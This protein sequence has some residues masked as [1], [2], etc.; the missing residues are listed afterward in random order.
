[1]GLIDKFIFEKRGA[2]GCSNSVY[3]FA[4]TTCCERVGVI[5]DGL[6]DFYW[7]AETP[8]RSI[9]LL[10]E[11]TCPFC[12]ASDWNLRHIDNIDHVPEHWRWACDNLPRPG[13]RR[14]LPL[15]EHIR[16][17][18]ALCRRVASPI[19]TWNATLLLNTADARVRY[20]RGWVVASDALVT[21]AEFTPHFEKLLLSGYSWINLSAYGIFRNDLIVGVESPCEALGVAAGLTS[22]NYSGPSFN[23]DGTPSWD[24]NLVIE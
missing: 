14:L 11:S 2:S 24:L 21:V 22:V 6:S 1:M 23:V 10:D 20:D 19:P 5:D 12:D 3:T 8:S 9:R 4:M 13:S 18:L 15:A 17:L 7:C 16:E